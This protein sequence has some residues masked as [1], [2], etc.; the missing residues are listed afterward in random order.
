MERRYPNF[1]KMVLDSIKG[2]KR[3]MPAIE[4]EK[5]GR[6]G[7]HYEHHVRMA[8]G[9]HSRRKLPIPMETL[10]QFAARVPRGA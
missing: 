6:H 5:A 8:G 10:E 7:N 4:P 9:G 1:F 2:F 3:M